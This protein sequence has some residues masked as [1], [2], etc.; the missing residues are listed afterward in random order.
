MTRRLPFW[1]TL[2]VALAVATMIGLGTWQLQRAK[3]KEGLL[4]RYAVARTLPV[5][6]FPAVP[7]EPETLLFRRATGYCLQVTGWS[8]KA[9]RNMAGES[10]WRHIAACRTGGGEGPGMQA[11]MGWSNNP[12]NPAFKGG[13]V[14]GII[15]ED[16]QKNLILVAESPAA[17]LQRSLPPD[18]KDIPNDHRMYAVQWFSFAAIAL[19]IY[20][21]ALRKRLRA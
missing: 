2:I 11:D 14:T 7:V 18:P 8:A 15:T 20:A 1:P 21:V 5:M 16:R 9:G 19:V 4:A 3:W 17:G 13:P 12:A 6:A 10:G